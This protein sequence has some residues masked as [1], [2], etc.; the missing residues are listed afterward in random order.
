MQKSTK[1]ALSIIEFCYEYGIGRTQFYEEVNTG[2][3][4]VRKMASKTLVLRT[5][6]ENWL[7]SLPTR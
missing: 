3:L 1:R 5:D 7:N 2:R 6:A 4:Q